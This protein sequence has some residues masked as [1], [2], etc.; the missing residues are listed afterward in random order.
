MTA[1]ILPLL[2]IHWALSFLS[3][4]QSQPQPRQHEMETGVRFRSSDTALEK[5]FTWAKA[6][7][8]HYKAGP[9]DP[10][11]PWYES[12]LPPRYAF[13]MRDVSHQ[14]M[15]AEILGMHRENKNMFTKFTRNIS[16]SKDWCSYWEIDKFD[17]PSPSDYRNDREFWYNLDANFDLLDACWR[18]WLWTGDSLYLKDPAF[19]NFYNRSVREY[20]VKWTLQPDSLLTR[21]AHPNAPAP[22]NIEDAFHR[23]RGLPS[24][25]EGV[26]NLKMGVDLVAALYRGLSS[27]A[28]ILKAVGDQQSSS[29]FQQKAADY[30]NRIDADW[31]DETA[32]LYHTYYDSESK[33]GKS[34]G[35]TFLLWFDALKDS[36][37][38]R[39]TIEHLL[40]MDLNVENLSYLPLQYYKN[41]YWDQAHVLILRLANPSTQRREY[42]EVSYGLIEGVVQGLM[43][44]DAN[45]MTR[46]VSTL[47]RSEE[48][49]KSQL[50]DLPVLNTTVTLTHFNPTRSTLINTG[51]HS[52][53]W[54]ARFAGYYTQ[55]LVGDSWRKMQH[56]KGGHGQGISYLEV[57][58]PPGKAINVHCS[59]QLLFGSG[60]ITS[61][62][63]PPATISL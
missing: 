60:P 51:Q 9:G 56:E 4:G 22:F 26:Q 36:T 49:A 33:F 39:H 63:A 7:A 21:P 32:S 18:S 25:S 8:L 6:M 5:A 34:E 29:Y 17:R 43:G 14:C 52:F 45:A 23:C 37:R 11:G 16:A 30:R 19:L 55:A 62:R 20:I 53:K 57:E 47:Y 12:A 28:G 10:V 40:S 27:Y 15:G 35:E 13:C 24:Y 48:P 42:P 1:K 2:L 61:S 41:G 44:V 58:V 46:T 59:P 3:F 38:K 50:I 31:W 54:K